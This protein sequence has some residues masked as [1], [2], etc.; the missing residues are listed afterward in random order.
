MRDKYFDEERTIIK[1]LTQRKLLTENMIDWL[2]ANRRNDLTIWELMEINPKSLAPEQIKEIAINSKNCFLKWQFIEKGYVRIYATDKDREWAK[3]AVKNGRIRDLFEYSVEEIEKL[4]FNA[5]KEEDSIWILYDRIAAHLLPNMDENSR[6]EFVAKALQDVIG[7]YKKI[8]EEHKAKGTIR[9]AGVSEGNYDKARDEQ[10]KE[11]WFPQSLPRLIF[12][13]TKHYKYLSD[14]QLIELIKNCPSL[15][16]GDGLDVDYHP[17][18]LPG[19]VF[20]GL[21]LHWDKQNDTYEKNAIRD[22][23]KPEYK[24]KYALMEKMFSKEPSIDGILTEKEQLEIIEE[25][26][27]CG[28]KLF[29]PIYPAGPEEKETL[30]FEH[31]S[32][33]PGLKYLVPTRSRNTDRF[34]R[35]YGVYLQKGGMDTWQ[36]SHLEKINKGK[37]YN[38]NI[39]L[40]KKLLE[41]YA[42]HRDDR[43]EGGWRAKRPIIF[44][45]NLELCWD[46][47]NP[48]MKMETFSHY[49]RIFGPIPNE[50]KNKLMEGG[51]KTDADI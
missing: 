38:Y 9:R 27:D 46:M 8:L 42:V 26:K 1:W 20:K 3:I 5:D 45:K 35:D 6:K 10:G 31:I 51:V 33:V 50:I 4:Y 14:E 48:L 2:M 43:W 30:L 18:Y 49:E 34:L 23:D 22:F 17:D 24:E 29:L 15:C 11:I 7:G 40:P 44:D 28:Y 47:F 37:L 19:W 32:G 36:I 39:S 25:V 12:A 41:D 16:S 13:I 21:L